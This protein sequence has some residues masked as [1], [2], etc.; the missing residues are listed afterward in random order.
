MIQ[1][2]TLNAS[3]KSATTHLEVKILSSEIDGLS[4]G[5]KTSGNLSSS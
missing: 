4:D 5:L 1:E 3:S 2:L